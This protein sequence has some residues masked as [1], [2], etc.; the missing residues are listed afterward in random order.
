[1]ER[2]RIQAALDRHQGKVARAAAELGIERSRLHKRIR[3]LKMSAA[4]GKGFS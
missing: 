2:E 1:M 3:A 4:R